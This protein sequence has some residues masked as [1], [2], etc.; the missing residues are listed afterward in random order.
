MV[1]KDVNTDVLEEGAN[2]HE[3]TGGIAD[4]KA[5]LGEADDID[6]MVDTGHGECLDSTADE[7]DFPFIRLDVRAVAGRDPNDLTLSILTTGVAVG[8]DETGAEASSIEPKFK[9]DSVMGIDVWQ[10]MF[11]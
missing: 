3:V 7:P 2:V 10:E 5:R 8:N 6:A 4:V 1:G 9:E 11:V